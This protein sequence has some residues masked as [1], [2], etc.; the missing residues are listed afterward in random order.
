MVASREGFLV[1]DDDPLVARTTATL[2]RKFG[3]AHVVHSAAKAREA[4]ARWSWNGLVVDEQ[5]GD[6]SG[7]DVAQLARERDPAIP[8]AVLTA[9][10]DSET[11]NRAAR[12]GAIFICKPCGPEEL[13]PFLRQSLIREV[14]STQVGV[15]LMR[16][17][18][19]FSLSPRESQILASV[20]GGLSR[21]QFLSDQDMSPNTYKT[22]VK[23][24][25]RKTDF[26]NLSALTAFILRQAASER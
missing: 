12:L 9:L 6:Q 26:L 1:V 16:I 19:R 7:M 14:G 8:V 11:V 4:I 15:I 3:P 21:E 17:A 10:L 13:S 23:S 2:V 22:H 5:L 25:L 24:L 18:E 20:L